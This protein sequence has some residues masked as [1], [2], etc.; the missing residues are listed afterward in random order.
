MLGRCRVL[1]LKRGLTSGVFFEFGS[2]GSIV[3]RSR[4]LASSRSM[5]MS[6]GVRSAP[7]P[8]NVALSS[9]AVSTTHRYYHGILMR[10]EKVKT[11]RYCGQ[12]VPFRALTSPADRGHSNVSENAQVVLRPEA[13]ATVPLA[14]LELSATPGKPRLLHLQKADAAASLGLMVRDMRAV[15][16]SFRTSSPTIV[17]RT[18]GIIVHLEHIRV[19]ITTDRVLV[20]DPGNPDVE[21]FVP[22]L[23]SRLMSASHPMP[24]ELRAVE[25]VLVH[26]CASLNAQL[27][28]LTPSVDLVLDTLS[29]TTDFGGATVQHCLDRLLPLE[30]RAIALIPF[31]P[32]SIFSPLC[33]QWE[34]ALNSSD[35]LFYFSLRFV[36][37]SLFLALPSF[38]VSA[39][40]A[41]GER[42]TE[43]VKRVQCEGRPNP[44]RPR[45]LARFGRG[46][47]HHVPDRV[48]GY[49]GAAAGGP[50]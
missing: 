21:A 8:R 6:P 15:D 5:P 43:C 31:S 10:G 39:A 50:T 13:P 30:A 23:Q 32:L 46:H 45:R 17:S 12:L 7:Q 36:F 25:G 2:I 47:V 34:V 40:V 26:V 35:M 9:L 42:T 49:R 14:A 28:T 3:N 33:C 37:C 41:A 24:F 44:Q 27:G 19:I 38:R 18:A 16:A 29:T 1:A 48:P 22:R 20:F 11:G 4:W